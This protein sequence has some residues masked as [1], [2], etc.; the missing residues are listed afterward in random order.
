MQNKLKHYDIEINNIDSTRIDNYIYNFLQENDFQ[1]NDFASR[2][3]LL[4]VDKIL[5]KNLETQVSV[6]EKFVYD[7]SK[8]Y[9]LEEKINFEDINIEFWIKNENSS[10][11]DNTHNTLHIDCDEFEKQNDVNNYSVPILSIINYLSD[12]YTSPTIITDIDKNLKTDN[13]TIFCFPKKYQSISFNGGEFYHGKCSM[14]NEHFID[15]EN[16]QIILINLWFKKQPKDVKT[17]D[18]NEFES[19]KCY[20]VVNNVQVFKIKRKYNSVK[21]LEDNLTENL[22]LALIKTKM[23]EP[24]VF[25]YY[26]NQ[27]R[28]YLMD[29]SLFIFN[30]PKCLFTKTIDN[31]L[32]NK[33]KL[34]IKSDKFMQRFIHNIVFTKDICDW[35]IYESE[36]YAKNNNGWMTNRHNNYATTDIPLQ[37]IRSIFKF[38]TKS[39][40]NNIN[41]KLIENYCI[42][43]NTIFDYKD[44]FIVKYK[45]DGIHQDSLDMHFDESSFS[46][47]LL[48]NEQSVFEGGGTLY[49]DDIIINLNIGDM[50]I[51]TKNHRHSGLK[52]TRGFRYLLVFFIDAY[53]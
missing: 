13:T 20:S 34:N 12:N 47:F 49:E 5:N 10:V 7:I 26:E 23:A 40:F 50:I 38:I 8:E 41:K 4:D 44:I 42:N 19:L 16:R 18:V 43:E 52:I 45:S 6:I 24:N 15:I 30:K 31:L 28:K 53:E 17:F 14:L 39:F 29:Y 21:V 25:L 2:L 36:I 22:G 35:I 37:N 33:N 3:F 9:C 11:I 48:L 46:V 27:I 1:E 51:H 32:I